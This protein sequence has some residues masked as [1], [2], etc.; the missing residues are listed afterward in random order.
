VPFLWHPGL[1]HYGRNIKVPGD[2]RYTL[3]VRVAPPALMRHD[4]ANGRRYA[5]TV[6]VEVKDVAIKTGRE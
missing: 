1:H 4:E 6:E 3:R 2:G 5:A